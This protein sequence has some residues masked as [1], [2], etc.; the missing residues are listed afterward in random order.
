MAKRKLHIKEGKMT[1]EEYK[2]YLD[3]NSEL[4]KVYKKEKERI[5]KMMKVIEFNRKAM[6]E[7][8]AKN[9]TFLYPEHQDL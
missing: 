1:E 6:L 3:T 4:M 2:D 9:N 8:M 5:N 7:N